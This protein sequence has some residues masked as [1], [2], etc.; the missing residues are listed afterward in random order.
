MRHGIFQDWLRLA[1]ISGLGVLRFCMARHQFAGHDLGVGI[2][3]EA[4]RR[5]EG[6]LRKFRG[7][8]IQKIQL[9][10][11]LRADCFDANRKIIQVRRAPDAETNRRTIV[12]RNAHFNFVAGMTVHAIRAWSCGFSSRGDFGDLR[13]R[14]KRCVSLQGFAQNVTVSRGSVPDE[15]PVAASG[16]EQQMRS[17][18]EQLSGE[19]MHF[20]IRRNGIHCHPRAESTG[21]GEQ[22]RGWTNEKCGWSRRND[23][24]GKF[25][26]R[27]TMS[28]ATGDEHRCNCRQRQKEKTIQAHLKSRKVYSWFH[29]LQCDTGGCHSVQSQS[30][31]RR[32][33][34]SRKASNL[35]SCL[36][37][38][39]GSCI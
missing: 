32:K 14:R 16:S 9:K 1:E 3:G 19:F 26:P 13:R 31:P 30:I 27:F 37:R 15:R 28:G 17:L 38:P 6:A 4:I 7:L 2:F 10:G 5:R 8:H 11:L 24:L 25:L 18:A 34:R 23:F 33:A 12:H 21:I 29:R 22:H 39:V 36:N 35:S 20:R